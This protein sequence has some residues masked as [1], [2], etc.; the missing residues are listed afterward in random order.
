MQIGIFSDVHGHLEELNQ[1]LNLFDTH[2]VDQILCAGDLVDKGNNSDAVIARMQ[3]ACIPCV[4]GNHDAKAGYTWLTYNQPLKDESLAY[5]S[6]LTHDLTFKWRGVSVY[7]CHANPWQDTS[8]YVF[9]DRPP[10]LFELIAKAVDSDIIIMGHTHQPMCVP[11]EKKL[12]INPGSIYGN[13]DRDE[14]TC[15]ILTLPD[16][17]LTF[18]DIDTGEPVDV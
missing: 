15:C 6:K 1:T 5:L 3:A 17:Q 16:R 2:Q 7:L 10:S 9:P 13:R 12:L 18:F 14:R 8:V 11:V 4:L